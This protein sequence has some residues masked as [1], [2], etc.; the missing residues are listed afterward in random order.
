VPISIGAAFDVPAHDLAGIIR[1][2]LIFTG[3][4][5][6]LQGLWGHRFPLLEGHSGVMW[7][8]VLN[9]CLSASSMGL[10][11]PAIGGGIATGM[12]LAGAIFSLMAAF[13]LLSFMEK[14]FN[15]MVMSVYLFLLTFQLTFIFFKGMLM[16]TDDG[17]LD[18]PV[19]FFSF[20]IALLVI[21]LKVKGNQAIGNFSI[22]IGMV[23]GW[24]I[25]SLLFPSSE[26][27]SLSQSVFSIPVF[28]YGQP[29]LNAGIVIIT[30]LA[31][32]L[33]LSN[34]IAATQAASSVLHEEV[35]SARLNRSYILTGAYSVGAAILGL[36][37]YAPFASSIGFLESTRIFDRKPFL[38][39]G[40]L[41][42]VL[43]MI[44][45]LGGMMATMPITVGNAILFAAYL[46]LFGTSLKSLR[47]Y[48]F[49]SVTIHRLGLP[50]LLGISIMNVDPAL[51]SGLPA[52]LQPLVT[53]GFIVGVLVSIVLE[54]AI[55]WKRYEPV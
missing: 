14:V 6:I 17:T 13:N 33:N 51:F 54:W 29:N 40:G 48:E 34:N 20:G 53:N 45:L 25:Y 46:Q 18:L 19:S 5:C 8:L 43:G 9:L 4:A 55:D 11:L 35:T 10:D 1:S 36:V 26:A 30:F 52:L 50:V 37:S 41:L 24:I 39:G 42:I 47:H 27:P 28:P 49:D 3:L 31:S 22:L 32:F 38:I 15:P 21:L 16:I 7:G 23:A 44:P 12:L 2:S